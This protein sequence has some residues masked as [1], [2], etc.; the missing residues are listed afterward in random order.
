MKTIVFGNIPLDIS[1]RHDAT[2]SGINGGF[3]F[4]VSA[5]QGLLKYSA[6]ERFIFLSRHE[7]DRFSLTDSN[8]FSTYH[9]NISIA[10]PSQITDL[11]DIHDSILVTTTERMG[12][13]LWLREVLPCDQPPVVAFLSAAH[14]SWFGR[15]LLEMAVAGATE[16]DAL[17]CATQ[18]S[19]KVAS[20]LMRLLTSRGYF[21]HEMLRCSVQTPLIPMAVD[22][23][24]FQGPKE[25]SRRRLGWDPDE[26]VLLFLARFELN[27][28]CDLGPL[29]L[30]FSRLKRSC[31]HPIRLVLAGA[32]RDNVT[33]SIKQFASELGCAEAVV[34]YP[35]PLHEE[36]I[37]LLRAGDI[38]VLPGDGV[39]ESFGLAVVEAMAAGLPCVVS[40][41]DGY[42]TT[43]VHGTTGFLIPTMWAELG[44]CIDA[45]DNLG[46]DPASILAATTLVDNDA[47]DHYLRLLIDNRDLRQRMGAESQRRAFTYFDWPVVVTQYDELFD[48]LRDQ[49][50]HRSARSESHRSAASIQKW[51]DS[52]PARILELDESLSITDSG[53]QWL[54]SPYRLEIGLSRQDLID[55]NLCIQI[56]RTSLAL[57]STDLR[58]LVNK[59]AA[60]TRSPEWLIHANA[61]RLLKYGILA[62]KADRKEMT[63]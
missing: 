23:S 55:H 27:G 50:G 14:P 38:F 33:S 48:T 9:R 21:N 28:K 24:E 13:L 25:E 10:H 11:V 44:P 47:L 51:F 7:Q 8:Q 41:W 6:Y 29:L 3:V 57:E 40:D 62:R 31:R 42:R 12:P 16:G 26:I 61:M 59:S 22:C 52:Y 18:A 32:D 56:A 4:Y 5:V 35:N 58:C 45:F 1:A 17:V 37:R 46:L 53:K 15:F 63:T 34:I 36:K 60:L 39:A 20:S 54:E 49:R 19:Q 43:V 2:R 30:A